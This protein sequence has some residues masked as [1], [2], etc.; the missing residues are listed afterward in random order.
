MHRSHRFLQTR[1]LRTLALGLLLS[2]PAQATQYV[3]KTTYNSSQPNLF[4]LSL[5]G[6]TVT[7]IN[8]DSSTVDLTPLVKA[9]KNT[10]TIESTPGKNTNQFSK[11]E[12]TLGAGENGKW[13]TLYKQEVGK[14][15]TAGRTEYAFV[16]TPD[17]S[18]KAGPVSVSAK[19]NSNQLAE[20]KVT[21]NGQAVT[22]L[23][24]NGNADLTPFLKPGKN[25]LTVKYKR[26]KNK[27]QFSQSVLTVGQQ[28]GDQWNPLVKWAVGVSD[29]ASGSFTFPIYH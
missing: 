7:L 8:N 20:F 4:R 16:A 13:R 28:Y 19:F 12:L 15:S 29:P 21:L 6:R 5:N 23:T 11:S 27:N 14:G 17:S 9:G 3:V 24:A 2:A 18:P 10:L 25:L 1:F 22:T 26:G